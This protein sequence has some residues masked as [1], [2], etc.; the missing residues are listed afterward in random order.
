MTIHIRKGFKET[1][2]GYREPRKLWKEREYDGNTY[3]EFIQPTEKEHEVLRQVLSLCATYYS[4]IR[5][6]RLESLERADVQIK[7]TNT[8]TTD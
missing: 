4:E 2:V 5:Q 7:E 6:E 8:T 3:V 1:P